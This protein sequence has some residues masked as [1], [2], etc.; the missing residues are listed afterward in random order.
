MNTTAPPAAHHDLAIDLRDVAK[1]YKGR[2]AA[3]RGIE[4][5]VRRGEIFGFLGPNGAGKTTTIRILMGLIAATGGH[6]S[7]FGDRVP[8]IVQFDD[9]APNADHVP[10]A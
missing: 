1:T 7:I 4:M 6:A 10:R 3:L 9:E 2:V 8:S 5:H